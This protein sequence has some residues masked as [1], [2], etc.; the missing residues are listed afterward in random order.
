MKVDIPTKNMVRLM[1]SKKV[2]EEMAFVFESVDKYR[3]LVLNLHERIR[4]LEDKIGRR[5]LYSRDWE[6]EKNGN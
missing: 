1:V 3:A 2:R 5:K 6:E 4:I